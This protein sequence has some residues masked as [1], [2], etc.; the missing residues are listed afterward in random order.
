MLVTL[1]AIAALTLK[2][3]PEATVTLLEPNALLLDATS[4]PLLVTTKGRLKAVFAPLNTRVP[5][6]ATIVPFTL[7]EMVPAKASVLPV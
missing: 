3:A 7:P 1:L 2:V 5:A 6:S 4:A